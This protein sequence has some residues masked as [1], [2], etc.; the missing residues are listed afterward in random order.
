MVQCVTSIQNAI[1]MEYQQLFAIGGSKVYEESML[2]SAC[3]IVFITRLLRH[4][5]MPCDT[6]FPVN[7]LEKHFHMNS[8]I[9]ITEQCYHLLMPSLSGKN[10]ISLSE[11]K[12]S[13][14]EDNGNIEYCIEAYIRK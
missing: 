4:G 14:T 7:T 8:S 1:E 5:T 2:D 6:F 10:A 3:Q 13:V 11:D 12:L 9:N